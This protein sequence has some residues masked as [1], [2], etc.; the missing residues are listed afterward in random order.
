MK[1]KTTELV[2]INKSGRD[3]TTSL[4]VAEVFGKAHKNILRSIYDMSCSKAF[5]EQNFLLTSY[6]SL[7]NKE[8]PMYEI[9]KDGFTFLAMGFTGKN[10]GVFKEKFIG[11]F[12]KYD[13]L[14][15]DD[16]YI[17]ERAFAVLSERSKIREQL[18]KKEE[19]LQIQ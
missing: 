2:L 4:I 5:R 15:K 19:Q 11:E 18:A 8:M 7:Q 16:D 9:T 13:L 12:D 1:K 17:V 14:L 6:K 3:I 10:A